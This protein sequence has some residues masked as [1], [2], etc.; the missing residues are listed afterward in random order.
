MIDQVFIGIFGLASIWLANDPREPV[1][2][3][4]C[5]CGQLAQPFWLYASWQAEQWGIFALSFA[6]AA[7]WY[8]GF[9]LHWLRRA[10]LARGIAA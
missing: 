8:R 7:G 6:Y 1:R 3:W 4:A 10:D 5:I 9:R 2:R